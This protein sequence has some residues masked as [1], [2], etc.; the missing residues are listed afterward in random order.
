MKPY[1]PPVIEVFELPPDLSLEE[2][3][4]RFLS[5]DKPYAAG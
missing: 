2:W 3:E 1:E 4:K 5:P